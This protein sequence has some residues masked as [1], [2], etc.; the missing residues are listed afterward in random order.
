[1]ILGLNNACACA[2]MC[3]CV[4]LCL[5]MFLSLYICTRTH[6]LRYRPFLLEDG[7]NL[8]SLFS[9]SLDLVLTSDFASI[10]LFFLYHKDANPFISRIAMLIRLFINDYILIF[11]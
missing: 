7:V 1:M 10:A 5:C 2:C 4:C 11:K 8:L 6:M 9:V 3:V